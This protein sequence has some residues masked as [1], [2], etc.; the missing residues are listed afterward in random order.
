LSRHI[1]E[2]AIDL[3]ARMI[4]YDPKKRITAAEALNHPYFKDACKPSDIP[5]IE[6]ELKEL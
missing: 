3:I 6:G 4:E 2:E 5:P 1:D